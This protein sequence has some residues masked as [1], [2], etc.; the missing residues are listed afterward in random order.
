VVEKEREMLSALK[1]DEAFMGTDWAHVTA[2]LPRLKP[3]GTYVVEDLREMQTK[4]LER[5]VT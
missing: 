2:L 4:K 3:D 1:A 5:R